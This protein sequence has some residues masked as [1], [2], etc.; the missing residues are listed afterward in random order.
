MKKLKNVVMVLLVLLL[1]AANLEIVEAAR[2]SSKSYAMMVGE[3]VTLRVLD[4]KKTVKWSSSNKAVA[5]VDK[6]GN[7]K[8]K[9]TGEAVITAKIGKSTYTCKVKVT[10]AVNAILYN[11]GSVTEEPGTDNPS[12]NPTDGI[13]DVKPGMTLEAVSSLLGSIGTLQS[14]DGNNKTYVFK[15]SKGDEIGTVKFVDGVVPE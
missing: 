8:A 6:K 12:D 7:V 13:A 15:D 2:I 9:K 3:T 10:K 5:S 11:Q 4:T 14:E 1:I